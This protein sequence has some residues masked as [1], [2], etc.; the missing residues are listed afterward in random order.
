MRKTV[1]IARVTNT[2]FYNEIRLA[3]HWAEFR[4]LFTWSWGV[5]HDLRAPKSK[6][7][8]QSFDICSFNASLATT[9]IF[10]SFFDIR[11][12]V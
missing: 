10:L 1:T 4:G 11:W 2:R 7:E 9:L 3:L 5:V 8:R 6:I 12:V